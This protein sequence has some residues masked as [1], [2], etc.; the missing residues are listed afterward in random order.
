MPQK[1]LKKCPRAHAILRIDDLFSKKGYSRSAIIHKLIQPY[2]GV[3]RS[4]FY[5]IMKNGTA[6]NWS[7]PES[8][9]YE[10]LYQFGVDIGTTVFKKSDL[11]K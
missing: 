6:T 8:K 10:T 2:F 4:L 9:I 5:T 3:G 1:P 7:E 11:R